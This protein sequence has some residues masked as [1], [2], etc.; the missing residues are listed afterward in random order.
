[1]SETTA[2]SAQARSPSAAQGA[3]SAPTMIV[4]AT[5]GA[6]KAPARAITRAS[7]SSDATV[8]ANGVA[9]AAAPNPAAALESAW[10]SLIESGR[11]QEQG[12]GG[13]RRPTPAQRAT[14]ARAEH[15][16]A[17]LANSPSKPDSP[18]ATDADRVEQAWARPSPP[19][20]RDG[21]A[22]PAR[23]APQG[24]TAEARPR[25]RNWAVGLM[26]EVAR[27]RAQ[28]PVAAEDGNGAIARAPAVGTW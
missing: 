18:L 8:V 12:R 11:L 26:R 1:M 15:L 21:S 7:R 24:A 13:S 10:L 17:A 23:T 4:Q 5:D 19:R 9:R 28:A 3:R 25:W 27:A 2:P 20:T 6:R 16:Q 14:H 22:M